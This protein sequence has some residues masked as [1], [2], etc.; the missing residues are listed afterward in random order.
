[1]DSTTPY[2]DH[3]GGVVRNN[4][5]YLAPGLMSPGRTASSDGSVIA[6][7]SP[8]TQI[9]HNSFLLN[10]NEF[11]AIEFRFSTTTNCTARN[12]LADTPVHL[13]DAATALLNSNLSTAKPNLF[14]NPV[15]ADLHLLATATNVID[16]APS[17][18][19]VTNDFDGDPRPRGSSSDI[20][21]DEFT[22]NA[23]PRITGLRL[24]NNNWLVSFTTYLG[25]NY[26]LRRATNLTDA[27]WS[28]VTGNIPGSG[29]V[30]EIADT[31]AAQSRRFYRA[32]L[33]P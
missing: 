25:E 8:G 15:A 10:S 14:V 18:S 21:A 7:N 24:S 11:Y 1:L 30:V 19:T 31:N 16:K 17:L 12:N 26:E 23:P 20:G 2:F 3:A 9:D 22:T 27:S 29:G 28:F 5:V 6:W 4:F 32:A 33:S 13:R